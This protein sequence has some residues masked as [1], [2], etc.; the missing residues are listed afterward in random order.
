RGTC[1][2]QSNLLAVARRYGIDLESPCGGTQVC[3]KCAVKLEQDAV[4]AEVCEQEK[5]LLS[6]DDLQQ[7]YRLACCTEVSCD[8]VAFIP[9]KS[10]RTQQ[11][12]LEN[13]RSTQCTLHPAVRL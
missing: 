2:D 1:E 5:N 13:G 3:G 10:R 7:G 11:G 8:L 12:I 4:S 6:P 9:E